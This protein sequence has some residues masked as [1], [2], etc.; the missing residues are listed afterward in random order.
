MEQGGLWRYLSVMAQISVLSSVFDTIGG[1]PVHPLA[2]HLAVVLVPLGALALVALIFL[3][4]QRKTYLPITVGTLAL[5]TIATYMAKESGEQLANRVGLPQEHAALGDVLFPASIGLLLLAVV[6][7]W[8]VRTDRPKLQL[9]LAMSAVAIG[10]IAVSTLTFFVGH[11]GAEATW[12]NKIQVV[13]PTASPTESQTDASTSGITLE[14]L[15]KHSTTADCWTAVEGKVIDLTDYLSKHPGGSAVLSRICGTDGTNAFLG[16]HSG[17]QTPMAQLDALVIGTLSDAQP[18]AL[19][20]ETQTGAGAAVA[21]L[22]ATEIA[23]H[24]T[25]SDCWS[26][27]SGNVYDLTGYANSHPGGASAISSLCG[28]DATQAFQGQHSGQQR[29][30]ST[31]AAF[32]L[33]P[34]DGAAASLPGATAVG[35]EEG[36]HDEGREGDDD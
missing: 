3:P 32:L 18:S 26:V 2:V 24:N 13:E 22:T 27:V 33:G 5:G 15:A 16:Q 30:E 8:L 4:G 12:A 34:L 20:T 9:Q 10:A 36:E 31:L 29:P 17:Q 23:K 28:K 19:P 7:W 35:G 25:T 21:A 14:E 11:S 1:L 6:F